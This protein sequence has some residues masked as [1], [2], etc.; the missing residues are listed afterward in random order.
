VGRPRDSACHV[1]RWNRRSAH[2]ES[3]KATSGREPQSVRDVPVVSD[4]TNAEISPEE[5]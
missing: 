1:Q 5:V 3:T 4:F 2:W